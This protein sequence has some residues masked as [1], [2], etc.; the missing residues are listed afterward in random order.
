VQQTAIWV[1]DGSSERPL[2]SE[3]EVMAEDSPP[4]WSPDGTILYYRLRREPDSG[5]ELWRTFVDSGKSEAV[6]PGISMIDFDVSPDAK[7]VV[8][9]AAAPDGSTQLWLARADRSSPPEKLGVSGARLPHFGVPGEILFQQ[10]EGN[11]N[12]IERIRLDGTH[13]SKVFPYPVAEFQGV[14]PGRRWVDAAVPAAPGTDLP[15]IMAIPLDGSPPRRVCASYCLLRWSTDG[16]FLFVPVDE[17]SRTSPG[18]TLAIPAGADESLP[19][20]PSGGIAPDSDP[21]V[22]EGATSVARPTIIPGKDPDHYA[23][24]NTTVHRNLYR[25][26]LH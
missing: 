17:S 19:D 4:L 23:W 15:S 13:R 21:G 16:K 2:S 18:R 12:Y 26:S 14:S 11:T 24:V 22:V 10:T 20:F 25:I 6:L 5:V 3:G 8:Y 9:T 1:H 7:Q